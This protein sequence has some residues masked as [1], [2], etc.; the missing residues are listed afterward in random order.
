MR[1]CCPIGESVGSP[2]VVN[3]RVSP[4]LVSLEVTGVAVLSRALMPPTLRRLV[5]LGGDSGLFE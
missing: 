4:V 1:R 2:L 3:L 5:V